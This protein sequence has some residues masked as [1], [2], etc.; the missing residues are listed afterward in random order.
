LIPERF[1]RSL[2]VKSFITNITKGHEKSSMP[3][4]HSNY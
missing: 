3:F 2:I 1:S 4:I